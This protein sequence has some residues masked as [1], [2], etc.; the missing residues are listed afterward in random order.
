MIKDLRTS[1]Y[2]ETPCHQDFVDDWVR[3]YNYSRPHPALDAVTPA[4]RFNPALSQN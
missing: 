2:I 3:A 1:T 4:S